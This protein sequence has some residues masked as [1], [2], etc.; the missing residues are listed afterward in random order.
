ME[1][2]GWHAGREYVRLEIRR[3]NEGFFVQGVGHLHATIIEAGLTGAKAREEGR[4]LAQLLRVPLIDCSV[5][6]V[7]RWPGGSGRSLMAKA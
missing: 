6:N 1:V 7:V 5:D 3:G 4:R 2:R